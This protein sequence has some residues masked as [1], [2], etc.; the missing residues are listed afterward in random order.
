MR[1]LLRLPEDAP[2]VSIFEAQSLFGKSIAIS[3][4][5][6]LITY[7]LVPVLGPVIKLSGAVGPVVGLVIGIVSAVAIVVAIRRFFAA[8]HKWRWGYTAIAGGILV[9][10]AFQA[11]V[12]LAALLR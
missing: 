4:V 9:L 7:V 2:R 1:R 6:C 11:V 3:A 5:R 12:D 10:L 8:D